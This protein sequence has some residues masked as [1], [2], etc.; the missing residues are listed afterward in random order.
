MAIDSAEKRKSVAGIGAHPMGPAATPNSG[1]DA[2][3]R[4]EAGWGYPGIS[5]AS[6]SGYAAAAD[7]PDA[8]GRALWQ[9][10]CLWWLVLVVL[11]WG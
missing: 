2:E 11:G 3:W 8:I 9:R 5:A 6:V 4:Q 10:P 7:S 1:R